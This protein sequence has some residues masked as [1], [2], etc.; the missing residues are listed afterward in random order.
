MQQPPIKCR[1]EVRPRSELDNP[2][3]HFCPPLPNFYRGQKVEN[4]AS[5]FDRTRLKP[6]SFWNKTT[7]PHQSNMFTCLMQQWWSSILPKSA[8]VWST[9]LSLWEV[10]PGS[11]PLKKIAKLSTTQPDCSVA[12]K[13]GTA[14]PAV[15]QTFK[16][17]SRRSW[18]W[19]NVTVYEF[20]QKF[21][22]FCHNSRIW[23]TDR[24]TDTQKDLRSPI[25]HCIQCSVVKIKTNLCCITN[26]FQCV[27]TI[28]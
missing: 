8:A 24:Q 28:C 14:T 2:T 23:Q 26:I 20:G 15:M 3:Q 7:Y 10:D 4:L 13:Y 16:V 22:S 12:L 11:L 21:C 9:S 17:K 27:Q 18:S 6:S 19:H 5:I 1:L 25:L